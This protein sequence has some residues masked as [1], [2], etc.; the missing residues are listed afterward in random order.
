MAHQTVG[1]VLAVC[2]GDDPRPAP[3]C[4]VEVALGVLRGRWTP[5]VLL[6][7]RDGTR[8][9]TEL[10]AALPTLSDK[11]LADRLAQL[12]AAG[13]LARRRTRGWPP[14]VTYDLTER[15]AALLPLLGALWRWGATAAP[16]DAEPD[17][18]GE[19]GPTTAAGPVR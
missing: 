10:A 13:V 17:R 7:F 18:T 2:T 14:R 1:D 6:Q 12:T 5:L 19:V 15:G 8:S 9:F 16:R 11:V 4:P 3:D